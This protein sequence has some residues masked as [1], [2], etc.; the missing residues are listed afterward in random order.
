MEISK[1][2]ELKEKMLHERSGFDFGGNRIVTDTY[3]GIVAAFGAF[4]YSKEDARDAFIRCAT[5]RYPSMNLNLMAIFTDNM[6]I[7]TE[8]SFTPDEETDEIMSFEGYSRRLK[9]K[10]A[11]AVKDCYDKAAPVKLSHDD[12]TDDGKRS[13]RAKLI[14]FKYEGKG[15]SIPEYRVTDNDLYENLL[16]KRDI[17]SEIYKEFDETGDIKSVELLWN[18]Q[19]DDLLRD[20]IKADNFLTEEDDRLLTAL[21]G[22]TGK[23][24]SVSFEKNGIVTPFAKFYRENLLRIVKLEDNISSYN[25]SNGKEGERIMK[26]LGITWTNKLYH[27]DIKEVMFGGKVIYSK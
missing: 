15:N 14:T 17:V 11:E 19:H 7:T 1:L 13:I 23:S 27:T 4:L 8:Y 12:L 24:V 26:M 18:R 25:F 2:E 20:A 22:T 9:N 21:Y 10:I 3:S 5:S 6:L 16:G